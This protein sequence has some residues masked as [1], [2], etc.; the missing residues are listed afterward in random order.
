MTDDSRGPV[1]RPSLF[2][3]IRSPTDN[4]A[5]KDFVDT[6][7]PFVEWICSKHPI[8]GV[9]PDDI[10]Q[11]VF[12]RIAKAIQKFE[13]DPVKGRFR[14]WIRTVTRNCAYT[15]YKRSTRVGMELG[16]GGDS[17]SFDDQSSDDTVWIDVFGAT[18][19]KTAIDRISGEFDSETWMVFQLGWFKNRRP[20]EIADMTGRPTHWVYKAKFNVIQRLIKEV[21]YLC[22]DTASLQKPKKMD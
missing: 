19:L 5:W 7:A 9:D 10:V 3:R 11:D 21:R 17:F 18:I 1:S 13:H 22:S 15:H 14:D 8:A 20:A 12:I 6:Y 4:L 2:L 16:V